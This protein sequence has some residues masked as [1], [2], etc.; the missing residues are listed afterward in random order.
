MHELMH[1]IGF[2]HQHQVPWR[3]NYVKINEE[4]L[5]DGALSAYYP[6]TVNLEEFGRSYDYDSITHYGPT[7][8]SKDRNP[9]IEALHPEKAKNMGQRE[10][11]STTDIARITQL[12]CPEK[13]DP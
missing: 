1:S 9:V 11:L 4:N 8:G 7:D 10:K 5:A 13:S 6:L 3:D 12:Y 2:Y